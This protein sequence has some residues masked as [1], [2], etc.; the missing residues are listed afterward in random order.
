MKTKH[1][2]IKAQLELYEEATRKRAERPTSAPNVQGGQLSSPTEEKPLE[3][4][5]LNH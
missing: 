3:R 2:I 4:D 5:L 1:D